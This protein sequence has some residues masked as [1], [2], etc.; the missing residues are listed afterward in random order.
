[1]ETEIYL[2]GGCFWGM[3]RYFQNII[4]VTK[5]E[6]GYAF[7]KDES[8]TSEMVSNESGHVETVHLWY[9]KDILPLRE[10]LEYYFYVIDPYRF[11]GQGN[12]NKDQYRTGIYY[13]NK[14][15][16]E[17]IISF[18]KER[19]TDQPFAIEVLPL[20]TFIKAEVKHQ[21]YLKKHP[22]GYCHIPKEKCE[23]V[24]RISRQK[25]KQKLTSEQY[26]VTQE[27]GTEPPFENSYWNQFEPGI[28][29][30][31]VSREP[32]F[33][34]CDKFNSSC[35]WPS[36]SAPISDSIELQT[37]FSNGM[38]RKEVRSK[39]GNS[40]LGHVFHDGPSKLGGLRYCI[41]SAALKFI[42]A[43]EMEKEGYGQYLKQL[44]K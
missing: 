7:G 8:V 14:E 35:G 2:A 32:L 21:N 37:D 36:F 38:I 4:G 40:H 16:A 31:I 19:E 15:D 44:K 27:K 42:K 34:S 5:T 23:Q 30:D 33:L 26:D 43:D 1:M 18:L 12:D 41:N 13:R 17:I 25:L 29:V 28:Y 9:L 3:E 22:F 11:N 39:K 6:V 20:L 24:K 10:L